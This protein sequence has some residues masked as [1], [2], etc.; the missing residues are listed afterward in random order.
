VDNPYLACD[1]TELRILAEQWLRAERWSRL[2]E[3]LTDVEF[4]EAKT[5]RIGI[6]AVLK[7]CTDALESRAFSSD[8]GMVLQA[9]Q[10]TIMQEVHHLQGWNA[11]ENKSYFLQQVR[12]RA[13][14][15]GAVHLQQ[16]A[17]MLLA[18][19]PHP[20][21]ALDWV[22]GSQEDALVRTLSIHETA[23][24][25]I[26]LLPGDEEC[27]SA[28]NDSTL[29]LWDLNSGRNVRTFRGHKNI[30]NCVAIAPDGQLAISSSDDRTVKVWDVA[31]G[32]EIGTLPT[33]GIRISTI[34]IGPSGHQV[35][36]AGDDKRV[37]KLHEFQDS[38]GVVL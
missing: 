8:S 24:K 6:D 13:L 10:R 30:V 7:D 16:S 29:K 14:R 17:D 21:L 15:T 35:V 32:Y 12:N 36:L 1:D 5:A 22:A 2:H 19:R 18:Q 28:S 31:T 4:L 37:G 11:V 38:S 33:K 9:V 26:A 34:A 27:I 20:Y 25:H 3:L 23:I